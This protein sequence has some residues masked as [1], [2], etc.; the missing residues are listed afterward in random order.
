QGR[1]EKAF[2]I[3]ET[4]PARY[5][6]LA[7]A[8]DGLGCR[9]K[10]RNRRLPQEPLARCVVGDSVLDECVGRSQCVVGSLMRLIRSVIETA[11]LVFD[12]VCGRDVF[13]PLNDLVRLVAFC[14]WAVG[15]AR[16][17]GYLQDEDMRIVAHKRAGRTLINRNDAIEGTSPP[18]E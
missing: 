6:H 11:T 2:A 3:R 15:G 9:E 12:L 5:E 8:L 4:D 17:A 14:R 13:E 7:M 1:P 10:L 18:G 16:I